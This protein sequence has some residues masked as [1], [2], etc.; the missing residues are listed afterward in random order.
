MKIID[1][2]K[3]F[4]K[5]ANKWIALTD[6]N[7]VIC[8]A[9]SLEEVIKKAKIKGYDEPVTLRVPDTGIEFVFYVRPA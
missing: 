1:Y 2:T 8:A 4:K 6:D 7:D 9:G 3:I 5:Y